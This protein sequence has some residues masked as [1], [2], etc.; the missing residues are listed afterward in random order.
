MSVCCS[1]RLRGARPATRS[2]GGGAPRAGGRAGSLPALGV[3]VD[4]ERPQ[5]LEPWVDR[6]VAVGVAGCQ[7]LPAF[8]AQAGAVGLAQRRDRLLEAD[9]GGD[10]GSKLELPVVGEARR[11]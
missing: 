4:P 8:G 7:A 3:G 2:G 9:R 10:Q 11:L 5:R 6:L 1:S